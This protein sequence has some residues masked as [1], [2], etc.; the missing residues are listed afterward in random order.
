MFEIFV[1]FAYQ[2]E[3]NLPVPEI[4]STEIFVSTLMGTVYPQHVNDFSSQE[5]RFCG[6]KKKNFSPKRA[7]FVRKHCFKALCCSFKH[8]QETF[9]LTNPAFCGRKSNHQ[10]V[11]ALCFCSQTGKER[12]P[13]RSRRAQKNRPYRSGA[14]FVS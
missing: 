12:P 13:F 7:I 11:E 1:L 9:S 4:L 14:I 8:H 5:M 3:R 2:K 10:H 6:R